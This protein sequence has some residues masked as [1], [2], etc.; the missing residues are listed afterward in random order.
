MEVV[1]RLMV[2]RREAW[3]FVSGDLA[4]QVVTPHPLLMRHRPMH[5]N[6]NM[7]NREKLENFTSAI[8]RILVVIQP[9]KIF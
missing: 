1:F 8:Q 7:I 2:C 3:I 5:F 6:E 9:D 4:S